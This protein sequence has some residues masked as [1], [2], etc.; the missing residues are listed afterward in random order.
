LNLDYDQDDIE[1][2]QMLY[3]NDLDTVTGGPRAEYMQQL[4]ATWLSAFCVVT[5]LMRHPAKVVS[6]ILNPTPRKYQQKSIIGL[7][8]FKDKPTSLFTTSNGT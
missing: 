2:T 7:L 8:N 5:A 6:T 4:Q 1:R 3:A